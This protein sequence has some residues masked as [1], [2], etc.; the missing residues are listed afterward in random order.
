MPE[1]LGLVGQQVGLAAVMVHVG[2]ACVRHCHGDTTHANGLAHAHGD[3]QVGHGSDELVPAVV[4]LAAVEQEDVL[5]VVV[6]EEIQDQLGHG[7]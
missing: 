1:E 5:A 6:M 3:G 2:R 4:R 7:D